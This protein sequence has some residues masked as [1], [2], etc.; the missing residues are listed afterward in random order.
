VIPAFSEELLFRSVILS[1]LKPYGKGTAIIFSAL[2]FGLMHM[3]A[4]QLLYAT[5]AGLV[6]GAVYVST[7]SLWLCILIHFANNLFGILESY[8]FQSFGEQTAGFIC[9]LA[10]FVI[11][12]LGILFALI[13]L[14]IKR[15]ETRTECRIGVFGDAKEIE[16]SSLIDGRDV[17]KQFFC[18]AMIIYIVAVVVNMVYVLLAQYLMAQ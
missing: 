12:A 6:L 9:L 15:K 5:A 1:N 18:P 11:F 4:A 10:E 3:N 13:H 14:V 7:G 8:I 17:V 16:E 2:L